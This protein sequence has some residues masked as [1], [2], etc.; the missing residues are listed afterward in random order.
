MRASIMKKIVALI[1]LLVFVVLPSFVCANTEPQELVEMTL[2]RVTQ[3]I[4]QN[5]QAL[6]NDPKVVYQQIYDVVL[7]I[8]DFDVI[9]KITLGK[10]R[11]NASEEQI[12]RYTNEL[13][14][15]L[16]RTY[17]KPLVE[18]AH[19]PISVLSSHIHRETKVTVYTEIKVGD[20][21]PALPVNYSFRLVNGEWRMY[22]LVV[23]GLS[24][25]K[26]F[27]STV[28]QEINETSLDAV[29]ERL[30]STNQKKSM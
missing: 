26:N 22:D 20:G 4:E 8:I 19:Q 29:I 17:T 23:E 9:A 7:P 5:K 2:E 14:G 21:Q 12:Q 25:V 27:R 10:H 18:H 3:I 24:F 30:A 16:L 6:K 1:A 11:R 13:Q 15:M 28:S